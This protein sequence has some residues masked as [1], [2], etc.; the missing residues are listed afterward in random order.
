MLSKIIDGQTIRIDNHH[1][2]TI[3]DSLT[4]VHIHKVM[5]KDKHHGAELLIPIDDKEEIEFRRLRGGIDVEKRIRKEI[6]KAFCDKEIRE[7]F[8]KSYYKSLDDMMTYAKIED[9]EQRLSI[10]RNSA[11][12]I[13]NYFGVKGSVKSYFFEEANSYFSF[14]TEL[15]TLHVAQRPAD[16]SVFVGTDLDII[17]GI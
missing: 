2:G 14:S 9:K 10:A 4:G 6:R 11:M 3:I 8:I 1:R 16:G 7:N 17:K 5:N 15:G 13:A 12:R